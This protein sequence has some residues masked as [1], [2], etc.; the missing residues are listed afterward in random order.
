M[1]WEG[2]I[3]LTCI[4]QFH[5]CQQNSA[6]GEVYSIQHFPKVDKWNMVQVLNNNTKIPHKVR[7]IVI[8]RFDSSVDMQSGVGGKVGK[9]IG[10]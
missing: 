3:K 6:Y 8:Y 4:Q 2:V 5:Q 10:F 7:H 1:I 9:V